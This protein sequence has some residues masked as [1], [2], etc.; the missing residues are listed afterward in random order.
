MQRFFLT[1][2][3]IGAFWGI[4]LLEL[5]LSQ[6]LEPT[7]ATLISMGAMV[8]DLA[9]YPSET[10]RFLAHLFLH[11]SFL[12]VIMNSIALYFS[13]RFLE[14]LVGRRWFFII[15]LLSGCG[16]AMVALQFSD[17]HTILIGASGAVMGVLGALLY[18]AFLLPKSPIRSAL[19]KDSYQIIIPSLIPFL[20]GVS[21]SAHLGGLLTGVLLGFI[22]TLLLKTSKGFTFYL[23]ILG[24]IFGILSLLFVFYKMVFFN[25]FL[26]Q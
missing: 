16:G 1:Q 13:G 24:A 9:P 18:C 5:F 19:I 25:L 8:P 4:F 22:L 15:F 23:G 10:Y 2:L 12:H 20:S 17:P 26:T 14:I 6:N 7:I 3:F 21:Y 11:G